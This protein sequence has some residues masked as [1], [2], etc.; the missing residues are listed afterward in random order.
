LRSDVLLGYGDRI[1]IFEL[2]ATLKLRGCSRRENEKR[3]RA[4]VTA[5]VVEQHCRASG[6]TNVFCIGPVSSVK[7]SRGRVV[8]TSLLLLLLLAAAAGQSIVALLQ[9]ATVSKILM[10]SMDAWV[11]TNE[12]VTISRYAWI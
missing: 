9:V 5:H 10:T 2:H 11:I 6:F 12:S 7:R 3:E 4:H 8:A 1:S